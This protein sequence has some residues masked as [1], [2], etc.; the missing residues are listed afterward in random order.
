MHI[1]VYYAYVHELHLKTYKHEELEMNKEYLKMTN[2][3]LI[4]LFASFL[5]IW[6][7]SAVLEKILAWPYFICSVC[8]I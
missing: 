2:K 1:Y 8:N 6:N 7:H 5:N 4:R 3:T